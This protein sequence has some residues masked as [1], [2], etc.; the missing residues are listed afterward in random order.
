[1]CAFDFDGTLAPIVA[2]PSLARMGARTRELLTR[3]SALY[4]CVV[5][6]GRARADV[7]GKLDG[8]RLEG[9]IGNHGRE[10][11]RADPAAKERLSR[12]KAAIEYKL[13]PD[14]GL[15]VEDKGLSLAIHYRQYPHKAEARRR[16]HLAT[17]G[18]DQIRIFGGK[19][20]VNIVEANSPNKGI[21][22]AA[23]R[24][25]LGCDWVLYVG[26]DEND[27][28]AFAIGGNIAPVRVGRKK[29]TNATYYLRD[30][31]EVDRL[32]EWLVTAREQAAQARPA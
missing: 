31:P 27:E 24:D 9:V 26:D 8:V 2:H 16:I 25:R 4:P 6:S 18:I 14:N 3:L 12:W 15:W 19:Q 23:E 1:M 5:L 30:Q 17:R 10:T 13:G 22:L 7:L 20:V 21:A 11:E 32:L 28:D 29:D